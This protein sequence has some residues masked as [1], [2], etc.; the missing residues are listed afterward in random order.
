MAENNIDLQSG[1][2]LVL[3]TGFFEALSKHTSDEQSAL[4]RRKT[5]K[6]WGGVEATEEMLRW[7]WDHG[8]AA[9]ATDTWVMV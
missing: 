4:A 3:H 5:G 2:I 7:H 6:G 1:D 9:V 8:I